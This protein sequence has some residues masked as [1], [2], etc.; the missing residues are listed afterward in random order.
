MFICKRE[1]M[2]TFYMTMVLVHYQIIVNM[3]VFYNHNSPFIRIKSRAFFFFFFF[4][5]GNRLGEKFWGKRIQKRISFNP[6]VNASWSLWLIQVHYIMVM[7][8]QNVYYII[9]TRKAHSQLRGLNCS[10]SNILL[11]NQCVPYR[12]D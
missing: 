5:G 9:A 4:G 10:K 12:K 6:C 7:A 1:S 8:S 11:L 3:K 2:Q